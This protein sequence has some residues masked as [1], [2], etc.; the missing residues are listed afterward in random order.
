M[1]CNNKIFLKKQLPMYIKMASSISLVVGAMGLTAPA[2]AQSSTDDNIEEIIVSGQRGSIQSSQAIKRNAEVVVDS[3]TA[4]DI[5][6]LPDRSVSEALQ[7]IPGVQ[8]QRTNENRDP[9]RLAAE[10]GAVF[11]RGLSWVRTELN[12]RDI[13]GA[14]SGRSLGF[15]DVSADLMSG[16]DV[17]KSPAANMIEGGVG[18]TVNL[19]TRLPFDSNDMILAGSVDYNYAELYDKGFSS[20]N[21]LY[22]DSWE[23]D[24]GRFGVLVSASLAEIGNRTDSVTTGRYEPYDAS[25]EPTT[26]NAAAVNYLPTGLGFR[27]IDWEQ[28]RNAYSAAVQWAP[29][30]DLT[31][32]LQ[33]LRAEA[34]PVDVERGLGINTDWGNNITPGSGDYTYNAQ[35]FVETGSFNNATLNWNTRYGKKETSTTDISLGFKYTPDS[36]WSFSGDLQYVDSTATMLSMTGINSLAYWNEGEEQPTSHSGVGVAFDLRGTPSITVGDAARQRESSQYF[37]GAAMD[38]IED[39]EADSLAGRIDA[40]YK[41]ADDN[42]IQSV[43]FGA[44]VLDKDATTRQSGWNWSLVS[45]QFWGGGDAALVSDFATDQAELYEFDNFYDGSIAVPAVGWIPKEGMVSSS[46]NFQNALSGVLADTISSQGW[47]WAPLNADTAYDL[48]PQGDNVS[49]GI[50]QQNEKTNALYAMIRFGDDGGDLFGMPFDG[51][52][53]VRVVQTKTD[54]LGRSGA[55]GVGEGCFVDGVAVTDACAGANEFVTDFNN[56]YGDYASYQNDYTNVLPSLNLRFHLTEDIQLRFGASKALVRPNFS[57]LRPYSNVAFSFTENEFDPNLS[58]NNVG[59]ITAGSPDLKPTTADQLDTS[60][61]WYFADQGSLTLSLFYKSLEDYIRAAT[62]S[63]THTYGGRTYDFETTRQINGEKGSLQGFELAYQQ[64]F[65]QLPGFG[66]QANYTYIENSGGSNTAVNIFDTNQTGNADNKAL[67]LEGMS[68]SSYN[69][70]LMY[71]EHDI[72][73]RLA[74]NWRERYLLTT[75]AANIDRPVWFNDYGQ[76]DASVFYTINDHVKVGLQVT[77]LLA[78]ETTLDVGERLTGNYSWT[79]GDRR[80]AFVIRGQF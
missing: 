40:E 67:P 47:G 13:F 36:A 69:L 19:R 2:F 42:F 26:D 27:R 57:Q 56:Q 72:S 51:N 17:Y 48:D 58:G 1:I 3:I 9:A 70:A 25:G 41:F 33:A 61:E 52:F 23:T 73:A 12:G 68:R 44:R 28:E 6:A 31:F 30:D 65:E 8:L 64:F 43:S 46:A 7:R 14:A 71:E 18:G 21:G 79:Q 55:G 45:R 66:I 63:E 49:A 80:M 4:V 20:V 62:V 78:E 29:N 22:S 59:T 35:G 37:W 15:E 75:S 16:V 39:N 54:A 77:N 34:N 53:G 10:G 5:G 74:Y 50:N 60:I 11:V 32:T 38:H 76:L 24:A